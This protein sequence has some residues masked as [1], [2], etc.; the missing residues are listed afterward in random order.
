MIEYF[1]FYKHHNIAWGLKN[2]SFISLPD[3]K[4]FSYQTN[5]SYLDILGFKESDIASVITKESLN[6]AIE[7]RREYFADKKLKDVKDIKQVPLQLD[8]SLY[9]SDSGFELYAIFKY[10]PEIDKYEYIPLQIFQSCYYY[11]TANK[12][13]FSKLINHIDFCKSQITGTFSNGSVEGFLKEWTDVFNFD[14][15]KKIFRKNK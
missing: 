9:K 11:R 4:I 5:E 7:N 14:E 12:K 10:N 3:G 2:I 15:L 13:T 1:F 8:K 6:K